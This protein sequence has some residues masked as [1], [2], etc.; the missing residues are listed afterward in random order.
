MPDAQT[1]NKG[2]II[3]ATGTHVDL[4]GSDVVN[5]NMSAI[6]GMLGGFATV[7]LSSTNVTLTVPAG[8]TATPGAGPVQSQN[9]LITFTGTLTAS[10]TV[11]FPLP[12]YYIV[13]NKCIVGSFY[14]AL[15]SSTPG[16]YVCAPPGQ[17]V[18]VFCDGTDMHYV[19][20]APV[21]TYL[22]LGAAAVPAWITNCTVP[23]Y[24]NCDGTAFNGATYPQLA[25]LLGGTTLPDLRGRTRATL[26]QGTGRITTAG[27]G[28]DGSTL[29]AGGGQQ[30]R[31]IAQANLPA[32]SVS[33]S[34]TATVNSDFALYPFTS[35]TAAVTPGSGL[36]GVPYNCG[37]S[38]IPSTGTISGSTGNLGSGTALATL[39]PMAIAGLTLIRAG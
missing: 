36:G 1:V 7:A 10:L 20:L 21:G 16:N 11:T 32:V 25:A 12:G 5:P 26:N 9:A 2:I 27:G 38:N 4:W 15:G 22:D 8:F 6:D 17:A 31:T 19:N 30:T 33:V 14:I 13:L 3:P 37:I 39:P 24:L 23:P 28:V 35:V 18:H 29:L 34:G